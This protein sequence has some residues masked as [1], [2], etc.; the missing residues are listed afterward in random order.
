LPWNCSRP[1]DIGSFRTW[2]QVTE[3]RLEATPW[4]VKA[5]A[6]PAPTSCSSMEFD[7]AV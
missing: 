1:P 5:M 4:L 6:Q 3:S 2:W 7:G